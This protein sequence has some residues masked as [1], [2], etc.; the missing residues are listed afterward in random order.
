M[1]GTVGALI[2]DLDRPSRGMILVPTT[3]LI[4]ALQGIQGIR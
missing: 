1:S 3:P 2:A 4:D